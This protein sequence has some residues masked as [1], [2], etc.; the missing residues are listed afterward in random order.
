[1]IH[2]HL[3]MFRFLTLT[4]ALLMG[5][6]AMPAQARLDDADTAALAASG[7]NTCTMD[8][9]YNALGISENSG[10]YGGADCNG[11]PGSGCACN[12][13]G[14]CGKYQFCPSTLAGLGYSRSEFINSPAMQE[15]AIRRFTTNNYN[16]LVNQGAGAYIGKT[17]NGVTV[18]WSGLLGAAHLGGAGGAMKLL[19]SN[20]AYDPNDGNTALSQYLNKFK[21]FDTAGGAGDGSCG[22]V[23]PPP[24]GFMTEQLCDPNIKSQIVDLLNAHRTFKG[25]RMRQV[26]AP[27]A[28]RD[29]IANTPCVS[30][31]LNNV[32][33]Q[34]SNAGNI[35]NVSGGGQV[36]GILN[37]FFKTGIESMNNAASVMPAM[38]GFQTQA[39]AALGGLLQSL[40]V[41]SEFSGEL[42][43]M[44]MDMVVKFVQ[45][46]VPL[47]LPSFDM[48]L[49]GFDMN[50]LLPDN[51]AGQAA[52]DMI[53]ESGRKAQDYFSSQPIL[54]DG[55]GG[56]RTGGGL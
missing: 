29:Q 21:G 40:G 33:G 51:C 8:D 5:L 34:F 28:P 18:T 24:G 12:T 30:N 4:I 20:G 19:T 46:A 11:P 14:C 42:C 27:P 38:L 35:V 45:C 44:M 1:M 2:N 52:R 43:G 36:G 55:K 32:V 49:G 17:I 31:E 3:P 16:Y 50:N 9:Y 7:T 39:S 6:W 47:E 13:I 10:A 41:G 22:D 26:M 53:Y 25:E 37:G 23:T 54:P 48:S 56:F 15:E